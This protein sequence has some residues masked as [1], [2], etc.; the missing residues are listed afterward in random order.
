MDELV[1]LPPPKL[2]IWPSQPFPPTHL[3]LAACDSANN[4]WLASAR[5]AAVMGWLRFS[6]AMRLALSAAVLAS[7]TCTRSCFKCARSWL[8]SFCKPSSLRSYSRSAS[9]SSGVVASSILHAADNRCKCSSCTGQKKPPA[10]EMCVHQTARHHDA[11][12]PTSKVAAASL[13][14]CRLALVA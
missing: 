14:S 3:S 7:E 6:P 10:R 1:L 4:A 5:A 2:P 11:F 12:N 13:R 8:A 9:L